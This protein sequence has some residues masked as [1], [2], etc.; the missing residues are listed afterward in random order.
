GGI[1]LGD[2]DDVHQLVQLVEDLL[3]RR[4]LDV[5][6]RD[7]AREALV[8][9]RRDREREDVEAPAGEQPRDANE[10]AGA[11]LDAHRDH[12]MDLPR[13]AHLGGSSHRG[14]W[15]WLG[16]TMISSVELPAASI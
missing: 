15:D 14:R 16:W 2:L 9:G 10:H 11:V 1:E 13:T 8:M 12:V 4:G 6:D 3:Q 5:D 7:D